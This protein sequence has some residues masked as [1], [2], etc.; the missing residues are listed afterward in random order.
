[1]GQSVMQEVGTEERNSWCAGWHSPYPVTRMLK[2]QRPHLEGVWVLVGVEQEAGANLLG[3]PGKD[4]Q[5]PDD[6]PTPGLRVGKAA[7]P[8]I[9][10]LFSCGERVVCSRVNSGAGSWDVTAAPPGHSPA[11]GQ[12]EDRADAHLCP[13]RIFLPPVPPSGPGPVPLSQRPVSQLSSSNT[14]I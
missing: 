9:A 7:E 4:F 6:S 13:T 14:F 2:R 1:M 11:W 12:S 3:A 10:D 5:R 8:T